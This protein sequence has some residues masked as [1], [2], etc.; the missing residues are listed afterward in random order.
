M[1]WN[2]LGLAFTL[3]WFGC[4]C[5]APG[6]TTQADRDALAQ[7]RAQADRGDAE[8]QLKLGSMYATG[9]GV[10][11]DLKK[12]ARWHRKAAEQGLASAQYQL[13]LDFA[14]GSGV[15]P[16][17]IEAA[18]WFRKA[19]EQGLVQA[20]V[21]LGRAYENGRGL[22]PSA[23]E[24]VHWFRKAAEL[25]S[26]AGKYELGR[27]YLEGAGVVKDTVEGLVW[28]RPAA[29]QGS[30]LAQYRLGQCYEQGEGVTKDL[31][32]AYKWY[33]LAAAQD[34]L[35]AADIRLSLAKLET[36]LSKDEVVEAQRRTREFRPTTPAVPANAASDPAAGKTGSVDVKADDDRSE[37]FVD[38][39]F[40]GTSPARVKLPEG[41]HVIEVKCA[42]CKPYRHDI[43]ITEGAELNL[44]V[45]L[46]KK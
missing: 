7:V 46:E 33:N 21:E 8:A 25:G 18:K 41:P 35:N 2:R 28:L 39:S 27:S 15:K 11:Q 22:S 38:G 43:Q 6:Q 9:A 10:N 26:A 1:K 40:V 14:E 42:G 37:V 4:A 23:V 13:G 19:A 34:E 16:D 20:Q 36:T 24:A 12:A 31:V 30:A 29:E 32:E 3:I 17:A 44:K 45:A 5:A